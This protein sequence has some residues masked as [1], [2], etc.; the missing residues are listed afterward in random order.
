MKNLLSEEISNP[1]NDAQISTLL[2]LYN[3]EINQ[4]IDR[5]CIENNMITLSDFRSIW[6][7]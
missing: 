6:A 3:N 2:K 4:K 5:L 7:I 1:Q